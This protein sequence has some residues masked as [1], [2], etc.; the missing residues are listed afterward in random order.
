MKLLWNTHFM[1]CSERN[2]SQCILAFR[3][4]SKILKVTHTS[5]NLHKD[6]N[7]WKLFIKGS[8]KNVIYVYIYIYIYINIYIYIFAYICRKLRKCDFL[9][10]FGFS[11]LDFLFRHRLFSLQIW[12]C[13]YFHSLPSND[14]FWE[15]VILTKRWALRRASTDSF[16]ITPCKTQNSMIW[17]RFE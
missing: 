10:C 12:L 15:K 9:S 13:N 5:L 14:A 16:Y 6:K 3:Q 8:V 1:K 17:F 4:E 2:I 11:Y 7:H